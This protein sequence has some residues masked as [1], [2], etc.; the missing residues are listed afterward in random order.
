MD[1]SASLLNLLL[2]KTI[3]FGRN[4]GAT[5]GRKNLRNLTRS[6]ANETSDYG[7]GGTKT[8]SE[9]TDEIVAAVTDP[10]LNVLFKDDEGNDLSSAETIATSLRSCVYTMIGDAIRKHLA[11]MEE[12]N[13]NEGIN[14]EED[15]DDIAQIL[16]RVT[17][18]ENENR[19][20]QS[21]IDTMKA[22]MDAMIEHMNHMNRYFNDSVRALAMDATVMKN[23]LSAVEEGLA[24]VEVKVLDG[25]KS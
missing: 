24:N 21:E 13:N 3:Q 2:G 5:D 12:A 4:N 10:G 11:S 20:M 14:N 18:L 17:L 8:R 9:V 1:Q 25:K 6:K 22:K 23:G 7:S 16:S 15:E 19:G